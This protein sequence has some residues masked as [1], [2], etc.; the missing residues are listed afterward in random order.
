VLLVNG[1]AAA[2]I[3]EDRRGEH[4]RVGAV[5]PGQL[6]R[7]ERGGLTA[8]AGADEPDRELGLLVQP[9]DDG[10]DIR[11]VIGSLT[12]SGQE[13]VGLLVRRRIDDRDDEIALGE[14][15]ARAHQEVPRAP[16]EASVVLD[17]ESAV[18][19]GEQHHDGL[20][21]RRRQEDEPLG[22]AW[23]GGDVHDALG[24]FAVADSDDRG[25]R[26]SAREGDEADATHRANP[27]ATPGPRVIS[28]TRSARFS[29]RTL[30][31]KSAPSFLPIARRESRVPVRITR[32]AP[33]AL[34]SWT[35]MSPMGPGPCTS[36]V[37]PA[38]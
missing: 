6:R 36:T 22:H 14:A 19:A 37:S 12:V 28:R 38:T 31:V 29:L 9:G 16:P 26:Q 32:A 2:P 5:F 30:M 13:R 33:R 7:K 25:E 1:T 23:A 17:L 18:T 24:D 11:H 10:L 15:L 3:G 21:L 35:A 20:G 4:D 8:P 27:A 34:Q